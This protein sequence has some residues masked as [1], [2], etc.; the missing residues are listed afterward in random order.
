MPELREALFA[1]AVQRFLESEIAPELR[2]LAPYAARGEFPWPVVRRLA[3]Q[4]LMGIP[5]PREHGGAGLGEVH[6]C[7]ALEAL[8]AV[9]ASLATIVG[10][11]TG[12][13]AQPIYLF[14]TPEQRDRH[15]PRLAT[16]EAVGAFCLTEPQAGSDAANLRTRAVRKGGEYLL[17]GTKH[18]VTNGDVAEVLVVVALT[19]EVLGARGGVTAFIVE[20]RLGGF[21]VGT[22]ED[23]MGIRASTTAELVFDACPVPEENVLGNVGAGFAVAL[24]ALDGGRVA[25]AAGALGGARAA[26]DGTVKLLRARRASG[27]A[28][29]EDQ[30]ALFSLADTAMEIH[31]ARL[32][33]FQAAEEV[34]RYYAKLASGSRVPREERDQVS[35]LAALVKPYAS[36]VASRAIDRCLQ[37]RGADGLLQDSDSER[38]FRD[39]V[40][41]EI[42]EGTNDIQ[43]LIAARD[44]LGVSP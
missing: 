23:K 34:E 31:H 39:A 20:K 44:L 32:A 24:T 29:D 26:L 13:C 28:S 18:Y 12:L 11:H 10:A 25:L 16:G 30:S 21:H 1:R 9:D 37:L 6:Y 42:F 19:D 41:A 17:S 38:A 14:G 40:I 43:R 27:A 22:V 7:L 3:A 36:E 35:R 2:T 33:A 4:G 8:G 15:L 5:I